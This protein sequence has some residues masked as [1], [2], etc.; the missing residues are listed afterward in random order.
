[1]ELISSQIKNRRRFLRVLSS[2]SPEFLYETGV[3]TSWS[4]AH[5]LISHIL[6]IFSLPPKFGNS[7]RIDELENSL[8]FADPF[9]I[10]LI[11]FAIV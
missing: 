8:S 2:L 6:S 11:F 4:P 10:A 5:F 1:M 7:A 9:N 3:I